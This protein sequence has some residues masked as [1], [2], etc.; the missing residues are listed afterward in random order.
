MKTLMASHHELHDVSWGVHSMMHIVILRVKFNTRKLCM[1]SVHWMNFIEH[2]PFSSRLIWANGAFE[3]ISFVWM[4]KRAWSK[5]GRKLSTEKFPVKFIQESW[6]KHLDAKDAKRANRR[7][8]TLSGN[9]SIVWLPAFR[10]WTS[11]LPA[12]STIQTGGHLLLFVWQ[13]MCETTMPEGCWSKSP[14]L[15]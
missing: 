14:M 12:V 3:L 9:K 6:I 5:L 15:M 7:W 1:Q 10:I 2:H 11:I 13:M 4:A 8:S